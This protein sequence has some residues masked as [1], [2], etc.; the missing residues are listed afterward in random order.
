[1]KRRRREEP[2]VAGFGLPTIA[3]IA[4]PEQAQAVV[5]ALSTR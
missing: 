2:A 5:K 3:S 1:M 4:E